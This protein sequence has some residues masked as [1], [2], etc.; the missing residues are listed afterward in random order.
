VPVK[1]ETCVVCSSNDIKRRLTPDGIAGPTA[2][3][4]YKYCGNCG[5]AYDPG[6]DLVSLM[7]EKKV[8][9]K[10]FKKLDS[11]D[12]V[13]FADRES[14]KVEAFLVQD[15]L[16]RAKTM[17]V[18]VVA[19]DGSNN[20]RFS[21]NDISNYGEYPWF[22]DKEFANQDLIKSGVKKLNNVLTDSILGECKCDDKYSIEPHGPEGNYAIYLGRCP[23]KHGARLGNLSD[24]DMNGDKFI[25]L[26]TH[27][28]NN[29]IKGG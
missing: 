1:K 27:S 29:S 23:H 4:L 9:L 25:E 22:T 15:T 26:I 6:V 14:G 16:M 21:I 3:T 2:V 24:L 10:S 8:E 12:K 13:Y 18:D 17:A 20:F 28:L 5:L 19:E 11:G 7:P